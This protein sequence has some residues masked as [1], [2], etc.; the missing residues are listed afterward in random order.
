MAKS[1]AFWRSLWTMLT[2][3]EHFDFPTPAINSQGSGMFYRVFLIQIK[4]F[5]TKWKEGPN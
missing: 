3:C 4:L 1:T 5:P 2:E